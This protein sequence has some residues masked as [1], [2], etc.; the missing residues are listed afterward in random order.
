MPNLRKTEEREEVGG[1]EKCQHGP[2]RG[3]SATLT[4]WL[5]AAPTHPPTGD[6]AVPEMG[7]SELTGHCSPTGRW[8]ERWWRGLWEKTAASWLPPVFFFAAWK[9]RAKPGM[10]PSLSRSEVGRGHG[11]LRPGVHISRSGMQ[12]IEQAVW[13][14]HGPVRTEGSQRRLEQDPDQALCFRS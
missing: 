6:K 3:K 7:S 4:T 14:R 11:G 13:L 2:H 5:Q 9:L 8:T 12:N 1:V 10:L